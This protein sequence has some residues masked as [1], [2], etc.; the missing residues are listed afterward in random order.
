MSY[1]ACQIIQHTIPVMLWKAFEHAASRDT[2]PYALLEVLIAGGRLPINSLLLI[3]CQGGHKQEGHALIPMG[4]GV[5]Q[6]LLSV[7]TQSPLQLCF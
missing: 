5:S 4:G 3:G 6:R 2:A 1:T 7:L